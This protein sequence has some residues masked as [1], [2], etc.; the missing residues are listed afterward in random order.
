MKAQVDDLEV[1]DEVYIE[2]HFGDLELRTVRHITHYHIVADSARFM[3]KS[4][5]EVYYKNSQLTKGRQPLRD[6]I[7]RGDGMLFT[8]DDAHKRHH[9]ATR[10][11]W[12]EEVIY[13]ITQ[14]KPWHLRMLPKETLL[15]IAQLL[16]ISCED[17]P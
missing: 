6:M 5:K 16:G 7:H 2:T 13:A 3:R 15:S 11:W 8:P 9:K 10:Q 14:L 1:G 4:G 17:E 12:Q